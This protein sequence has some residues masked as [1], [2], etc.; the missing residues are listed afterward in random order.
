MGVT[1]EKAGTDS[2]RVTFDKPEKA[3]TLGQIVV[4]YDNEECLGGGIIKEIIK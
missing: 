3:V 4:L 1:V 2:Y